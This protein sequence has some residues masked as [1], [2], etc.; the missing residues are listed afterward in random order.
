MTLTV[1]HAGFELR[2][3][4][5]RAITRLFVAGLEDVGP[6]QSRAPEV[7]ERVM[8][9]PEDSVADAM[10]DIDRRFAGRHRHLHEIF[11]R[12]AELM[13]PGVG[14]DQA[15]SQAHK[16]LLGAT[17]THEYS[18]EGASLCNPSA[19]L[20]PDTGDHDDEARFVMS[21]RG[22]GEGHRSSVGFRTGTLKADDTVVV[23]DP[24]P[25]PV[26]GL[27]TTADRNYR[28]VF[29]AK[30]AGLQDRE[31][32][33]YVL[34]ALPP[35]F[36]DAEL[37]SRLEALAPEFAT[38]RF[39][40]G[41][42]TQLRALAQSSYALEFPDSTELSERVLWPH[43]PAEAHGIEDVRLVPFRDDAGELTFYGTYTAFNG[44]H[45]AQH[46]MET[47]DF[48][49][50]WVSPVAGD[51]AIGKGLALFPRKVA[52]RYMALSRSDRETN[53]VAY[54]DDL[55]CWTGAETIQLPERPWEILQLGNCGSPIETEAGW[56][57]LTHGV[58]PMRTYSLGAILLDLDEPHR[59]ISASPQPLITPDDGRLGGYVANVVYSCGGF[60]HGDRLV[61][62]Y[63][64]GDQRI[65]IATMSIEEL[66]NEMEPVGSG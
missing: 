53:E 4:S 29:Q 1:S 9:L 55:H 62:P 39:A 23:D 12:H 47:R 40:A 66:L 43:S 45:I 13:R 37:E 7:I 35:M 15:V 51:A 22:I 8:R 24:G 59:V 44:V 32:A 38:R 25:F 5:T 14:A 61:V 63:G 49:K 48:R 20:H 56:L 60:A 2:P 6:G 42:G 65:S 17:F 36:S 16:L 46:M 3:D 64:I 58:G 18:I 34:E 27:P 52:G 26:T 10:A 28:S 11:G 54:S 57:V 50:F 21:V 19:V 31:I 41:T 33:A 30:V